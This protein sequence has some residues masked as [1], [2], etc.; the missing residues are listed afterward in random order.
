M[1]D[2]LPEDPTMYL[3]GWNFHSHPYLLGKG[4]GLEIELITMANDEIN[5]ACIVKFP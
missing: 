1:G 5:Y 4:E 2:Q 3:E